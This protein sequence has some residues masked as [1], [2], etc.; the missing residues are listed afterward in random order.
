M[1]HSGRTIRP[2]NMFHQCRFALKVIEEYNAVSVSFVASVAGIFFA[3][4]VTRYSP[5]PAHCSYCK[6]NGL[7][8][9][10]IAILSPLQNFSDNDSNSQCSIDLS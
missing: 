4:R 1:R 3:S 10:L 2:E 9:L 6:S 5:F 7:V 8:V